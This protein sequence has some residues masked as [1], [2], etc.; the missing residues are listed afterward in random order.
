MFLEEPQ[1]KE[2]NRKERNRRK[3]KKKPTKRKEIG[4]NCPLCGG[5]AGDFALWGPCLGEGEKSWKKRKKKKKD[6]V[7]TD[8][9]TVR[10]ID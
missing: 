3:G 1:K 9:R 10:Q 4:E 7:Q 8:G 2:E 6:F 5:T